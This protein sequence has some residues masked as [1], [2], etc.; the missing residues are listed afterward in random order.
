M[1]AARQGMA[2]RKVARRFR[3]SL[4]TV[5]RWVERAAGQRLDRVDWSGRS[6][7]P[8]RTTRVPRETEDLVLAIRGRL[9]RESILGHYGADAI[10]AELAARGVAPPPSR[11]TV[12]RILRRRGAVEKQRRVRRPPPP[13]GWYL[14]AVARGDAELDSIDYIERL[15]IRAQPHFDV[16]TGVSLHGGLPMAFPGCPRRTQSVGEA[17]I[18]HW[19]QF[20]RPDYAQF[21]NDT[22]FQGGRF[23]NSVG[24]LSRLCLSLGIVPVFAPPREHGLQNLVESFNGG[25]QAKV[26]RRT[27]WSS[28]D[29]LRHGS[30]RYLVALRHHRARRIA[31]APPRRPFPEGWTF[32]PRAPV[33]GTLIYVRRLDDQGQAYLLG[34]LFPVDPTWAHHLVRVEVRLDAARLVFFRLSRRDPRHQ[35]VL[36]RTHLQLPLRPYE[37]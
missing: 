22:V 20:G 18:L 37:G 2:L 28:I 4:S 1:R 12:G 19:R 13:A 34:R 10:L 27:E 30:D 32:D 9:R 29:H 15:K 33:H 8:Q 11:A 23:T 25:W 6:R 5:Q 7:R 3:V 14:P 35:S 17:L 36:K 16:L 24:R 31:Q 21:D 26:W